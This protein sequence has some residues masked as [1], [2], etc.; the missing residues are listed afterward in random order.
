MCL[1][2]I[3]RSSAHYGMGSGP[4]LLSELYCTGSEETLLE[5]NRNMYGTLSCTHRQDAGVTCEGIEKPFPALR[6]SI[7]TW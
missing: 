3:A 5:C 2:A 6:T 7:H 4:I 1:G